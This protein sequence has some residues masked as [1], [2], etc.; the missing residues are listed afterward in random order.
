V[1]VDLP[2]DIINYTFKKKFNKT[3]KGLRNNDNKQD[4]LPTILLYF[5]SFFQVFMTDKP[6]EIVKNHISCDNVMSLS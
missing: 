1:L 5:T 3:L 4:E 2:T 6:R